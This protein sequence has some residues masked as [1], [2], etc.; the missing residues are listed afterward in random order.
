VAAAA[1]VF[2]SLWVGIHYGFLGRDQ[3]RDT[4]RYESFGRAVVDGR[5]PYR[6]FALEYPP[7]SLPALVFPAA[8][9]AP[10]AA[11]YRR[12]FERTML[13]LGLA[14]VGAVGFTL[15]RLGA[16]P[17]TVAERTAFLALLPLLL[18]TVVLTRFDLW[19]AALAAAGIAATVADRPLPAGLLLGAGAAAKLYPALFV[20]LAAL[21]A[22]RRGRRLGVTLAAAAVAAVAVAFVPFAILAPHGLAA[23]IESQTSRPL[24]IETLG[25]SLALAAHQLYGQPLGLDFSHASQN[26]GGSTANALAAAQ[27]AA[28]ALAVLALL[29]AFAR[30][31]KEAPRLLRYV[32]AVATAFVV[33]GKVLSPQYLIWVAFPVAAMAGARARAA[34]TVLAAAMAV[35]QLWFPRRYWRLVFHFD[36]F[37]SWAVLG[38][39]LLLL[40]LLAVLALPSL[41]PLPGLRRAARGP[42]PTAP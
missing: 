29:V 12:A 25:S 40:L 19:P 30:G 13:V 38:R 10:G 8:V 20:P 28:Q 42:A 15:H 21:H 17:R 33:F 26:L 34:A 37:A 1:L 16:P 4:P 11:G 18:G 27:V 7:G 35:T 39:N 2:S 14:A 6:D 22:G 36:A 31:P 9:A 32:A 23:S 24:Q 5:L 41:P 3:I